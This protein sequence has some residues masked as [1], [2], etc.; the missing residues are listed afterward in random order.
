VN[1]KQDTSGEF[2][3]F[4]FK[5]RILAGNMNDEHD[6]HVPIGINGNTLSAYLVSLFLLIIFLVGSCCLFSL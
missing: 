3:D 1:F 6:V 4:Q 5:E 2:A